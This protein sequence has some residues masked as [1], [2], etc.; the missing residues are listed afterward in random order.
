MLNMP[1]LHLLFWV[2]PQYFGICRVGLIS[3]K[4]N[5][6]YDRIG[7]GYFRLSPNGQYVSIME[8]HLKFGLSLVIVDLT[9]YKSK[10]I[11]GT[12]YDKDV[13]LFESLS[14]NGKINW[15]EDF[16]TKEDYNFSFSEDNK[17][18]I[19]KENDKAYIIY[20]IINHALHNVK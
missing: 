15:L 7:G 19:I 10:M 20:D 6:K 11:A 12:V 9:T 13:E 3:E 16:M 2:D 8:N 1:L 14:Q 4:V 18:L 5:Y 17:T